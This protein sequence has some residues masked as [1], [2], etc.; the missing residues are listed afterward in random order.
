M[1]SLPSRTSTGP[2]SGLRASAALFLLPGK[3]GKIISLLSLFQGCGALEHTLF[4]SSPSLLTFWG[5]L[6]WNRGAKL[7]GSWHVS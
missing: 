4:L 5:S 3:L 1:E 6:G 2:E 7:Q